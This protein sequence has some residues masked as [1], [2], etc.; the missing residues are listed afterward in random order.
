MKLNKNNWKKIELFV[1]RGTKMPKTLYWQKE[2]DITCKLI[3]K[4]R[5]RAKAVS[6]LIKLGFN[7]VAWWSLYQHICEKT[8]GPLKWM[9]RRSCGYPADITSEEWT[10]ILKEI[11][12][13]MQEDLKD[14]WDYPHEDQA[15]A[16]YFE[17][18]NKAYAY[19]G[20]YF[21]DLWT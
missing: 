7:E 18:K 14:S 10:R 9:V 21:R 6:D 12:W 19:F 3:E 11:L 15:R 5:R 17:R 2:I 20:K 13:V 4:P 1:P 16:A 8:I